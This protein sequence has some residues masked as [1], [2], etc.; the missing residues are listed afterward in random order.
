[1]NS[2]EPRLQCWKNNELVIDKQPDAD[3]PHFIRIGPYA[4]THE[5]VTALIEKRAMWPTIADVFP[6]MELACELNP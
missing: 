5:F 4:E 6:S 1:E 3:E 2:R